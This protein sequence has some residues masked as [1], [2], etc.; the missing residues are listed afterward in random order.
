MQH[1]ST[2]PVRIGGKTC[3]ALVADSFF[4][5]AIGLMYRKSIGWDMC[6]LFITNRDSM[7]SL[8]M[9]NMLFPIDVLWLNKDLRI[10]DMMSDLKP[11]KGFS[12]KTYSPK[13]KA[14]YIIELR[15]GFLKKNSIT[16]GSKIKIKK[17]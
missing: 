3:R 5:R 9:Q 17:E 4:K 1:Y 14:R 6:M 16:A 8:T 12:L 11:D 15:S 7:Q 10:V 2:A 13:G